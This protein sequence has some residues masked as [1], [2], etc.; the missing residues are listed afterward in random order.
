ML[1]EYIFCYKSNFHSKSKTTTQLF[2]ITIYL[3]GLSLNNML[4]ILIEIFSANLSID[5]IIYRYNIHI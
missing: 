1:E 4:I 2:T 5:N 3:L